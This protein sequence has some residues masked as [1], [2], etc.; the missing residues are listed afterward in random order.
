MM[1]GFYLMPNESKKSFAKNVTENSLRSKL[2]MVQYLQY[3]I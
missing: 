3:R 2:F 1:L